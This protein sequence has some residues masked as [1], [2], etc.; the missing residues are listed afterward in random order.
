VEFECF[1][2]A[3]KKPVQG[4]GKYGRIKETWGIKDF[5]VVIEADD[6]DIAVRALSPNA[7]K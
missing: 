6:N 4:H 5:L 1:E 7:N 2:E 3:D